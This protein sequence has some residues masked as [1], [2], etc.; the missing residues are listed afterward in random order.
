[1]EPER[2]NLFWVKGMFLLCRLLGRR[3]CRCLT[4]L[5][6]VYF[7]LVASN[8]RKAS[9]DYLQRL[10][11][12]GQKSRELPR[13]GFAASYRHFLSFSNNLVDKVF[14][15]QGLFQ[16]N[17]VVWK[18]REEIRGHRDRGQGLVFLTAHFGNVEVVRGIAEQ[19]DVLKVNALMYLQAARLYNT[20]LAA[21]N[22]RA[23]SRVIAMD[24]V[25]PA[26]IVELR[27]CVERGEVIAMMADRVTP[28]APE[29]VVELE[30]LGKKARFPLGP[31]LLA[32]LLDCPVY[33]MFCT[34]LPSGGYQVSYELLSESLAS[35]R[36]AR[37]DSIRE[38]V[39]T[40]VKRLEDMATS[41]PLQWY[42]LYDYWES[43]AN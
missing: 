2:G 27:Q 43:E 4:P 13:P 33:T 16:P 38:A 36:S 31:Y 41:F 28:G 7:F 11:Q 22:D 12:F 10:Y 39:Q 8:H 18:G 42:N 5:V 20:V 6:A 17:D 26:L 9:I 34:A 24:E 15:W 23:L 29:K 30:F 1:M 14:A 40:Y 21:S 25:S 19:K 3:G 35:S 32:S 37:H